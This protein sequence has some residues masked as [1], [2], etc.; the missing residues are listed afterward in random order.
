MKSTCYL[1]T[2]EIELVGYFE[3]SI[4][5]DAEPRYESLNTGSV[6][7]CAVAVAE[8]GTDFGKNLSLPMNLMLDPK[9]LFKAS[10]YLYILLLLF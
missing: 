7:S 3:T 1:T 9:I 2:S 4:G 10:R 6:Q 5:S 8:A